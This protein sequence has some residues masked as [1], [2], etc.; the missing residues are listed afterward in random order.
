MKVFEQQFAAEG[1]AASRLKP[2]AAV[3]KGAIR[4]NRLVRPS[5]FSLTHTC[6]IVPIA[7][8][9]YLLAY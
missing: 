1:I 6:H 4:Q 8:G 7:R 5:A 3:F 9:L 2:G